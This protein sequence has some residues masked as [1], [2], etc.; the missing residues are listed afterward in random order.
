LALAI[1]LL[2][3]SSVRGFAEND[4]SAFDAA[5]R[6][7]K[8]F[9]LTEIDGVIANAE[10]MASAMQQGDLAG[11]RK[12]WIESHAGWERLEVITVD[13]YPDLQDGIDGWPKPKTGYHAIE[14]WLFATTPL[15]P[16][17]A[18]DD[19]L[20]QLNRFRRV[21]AGADLNGYFILAGAAT[22]AYAIGSD[23]ADGSESVVSGTS[24]DDMRNNM[25]GL[26]YVWKTVFAGPVAAKNKNLA[27]DITTS[28]N[29]L[30]ALVDVPSMAQLDRSLV[31]QQAYELAEKLAE[32][33]VALGWVAPN[34]K[35][36]D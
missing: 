30:A 26:E 27:G 2:S 29:G 5:S 28:M 24:L 19:L 18:V 17:W 31:Q 11:A 20:D 6:A 16:K 4:T 1:C 34:Y 10:R 13:L 15:I 7:Y 32:A 22:L 23:E 14:A 25:E 33:A 21:F 36:I 12:A 35:D 8:S 9:A 3:I